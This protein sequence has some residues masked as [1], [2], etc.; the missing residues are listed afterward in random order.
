MNSHQISSGILGEMNPVKI[1]IL[2]AFYSIH[3]LI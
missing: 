1:W 3:D 2:R